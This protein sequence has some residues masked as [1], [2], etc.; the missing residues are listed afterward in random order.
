MA[1]KTLLLVDG[2]GYA[3][4][5]FF[6]IPRL[7][8]ARGEPTNAVF[9]FLKMLRKLA[10]DL[11]PTH[12]AVTWDAGLPQ[13]RLKVLETYK[14]QRKPM[15]DDLRAQLP[16]IREVLE[17]SRVVSLEQEG[18]EA[19]DVIA[20]VC[21]R[22]ADARVWIASADKDLMQLVNDRVAAV[23]Q[24][25]KDNVLMDVEGVR[26]RYGVPPA[27]MLDFLCLTGDSS[28]NIPGVPGV[29]EKTAAQLLAQF[30]SAGAL[31]ARAGE[32]AN[33]RL[34][35]AIEQAAD[36]LRRNRALMTLN[37]SL[38]VPMDWDRMRRVEPDYERLAVLFERF[39]FKSLLEETRRQTRP[40]QEQLPLM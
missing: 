22:A 29:G 36:R 21:R 38:P 32:V 16:A 33:P 9:G 15:P 12:W 11:Q 26:E 27:Q 25:G 30:S 24:A 7:T 1:A 23:R 18:Y 13:E 5:A 14:A 10:D 19:D 3:Y 2:H 17:A 6:A 8:N 20:S 37:D 34:R 39:G 35:A 40:G 4:R 31:L 28:D